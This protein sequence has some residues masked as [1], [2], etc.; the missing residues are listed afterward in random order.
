MIAREHID[1]LIGSNANV[2][3]SEG[4]KIGSL[5]ELYLDDR[6]NEPNWAT[7]KTGLFGTSET[8]VPLDAATVDGDDIR[9]PYTK[10]QVKDAPRIDPGGHLSEADEDRL[11]RH[12]GLA[13]AGSFN[14]GY[15]GAAGTAAAGTAGYT[16]TED[17]AGTTG[18]EGTAGAAGTRTTGYDTSGPT[19]DDA[20]TRSEEQLNVGK[21]TREAGRARLRK[22][23]VSENVTQTVPVSREE[24]RVEREPITDANRDAAMAGPDL[25]EEE[26]E[27]VLHEERPVVEKETVPV[28]RVRLDTETVTDEETVSEQVRK[29]QIETDGEDTGRRDRGL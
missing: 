19:T 27:V 11:Y 24:V 25:S 29:E 1:R 9:V 8:F 21:E 13:G 26:H 15:S 3:D 20:M 4:N 7:V 12:Y 5:G 2:I 16:G 28:E 18:Y 23:I 14:T 17:T 10:D 6:T 22:Y